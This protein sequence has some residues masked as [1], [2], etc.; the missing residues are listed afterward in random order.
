MPLFCIV[1]FWLDNNECGHILAGDFGIW[2]GAVLPGSLRFARAF[3]RFLFSFALRLDFGLVV[4]RE[5]LFAAAVMAGLIVVHGPAPGYRRHE[6]STL[7]EL[8]KLD[9]CGPEALEVEELRAPIH[10]MIMVDGTS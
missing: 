3:Y 10:A 5:G 8:E 7:P 6:H 1:G 2:H 4:R 9:V